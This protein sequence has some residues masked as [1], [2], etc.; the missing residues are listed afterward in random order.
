MVVRIEG[1]E[2]RTKK[3]KKG[4]AGWTPESDAEKLKFPG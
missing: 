3:S 2:L 1:K 4:W